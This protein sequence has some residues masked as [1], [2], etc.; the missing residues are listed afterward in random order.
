MPFRIERQGAGSINAEDVLSFQCYVHDAINQLYEDA[1]DATLTTTGATDLQTA[2]NA[3][4][5]NQLLEIK[6]NGTYNPI[7]INAGKRIRVRTAYGYKPQLTGERCIRLKDGCSGNIISGL[8]IINHTVGA[9]RDVNGEGSAITFEDHNMICDNLIF[10]NIRI[11]PVSATGSAVLLSYHQSKSGD[12]YATANALNEFSSKIAFVNCD[13]FAASSGIEH[14][15]FTVRGCDLLYYKHNHID[16]NN[17]SV[18]TSDSRGIMAQNCFNVII[19]ENEVRNTRIGNG[20]C[21]KIDKI[22][23]PTYQNSCWIY[24]NMVWNGIEGIDVDD[25]VESLVENNLAFDCADEGIS[26]DNNSTGVIVNNITYG[27]NDGI[28]CENGSTYSL[29]GNNSFDN[30]NKNIRL[31]DGGSYDLT[32]THDPL[33]ANHHI[34]HILEL[35][36][37]WNDILGY[38]AKAALGPTPPTL[39][40]FKGNIKVYAFAVNDEVYMEY[41]VPHDHKSNTNLYFHIHWTTNGVDTNTVFIIRVLAFMISKL[42][43]QH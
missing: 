37:R 22:G 5:D 34:G 27:C 32:N 30:T 25:A 18:G 3:L 21:I 10:H 2:I 14:S 13:A 11:K 9:G 7:T 38:L 26:I 8:E 33:R 17:D 15:A 42:Q 36:T 31:D 41:Q 6:A 35:Q 1:P 40:I 16:G 19:T 29:H 43:I 12:N 24:D 23:T 28:R 39:T 20:E 4:A